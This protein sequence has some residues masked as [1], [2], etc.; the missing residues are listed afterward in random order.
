MRPII[1]SF[2]IFLTTSIAAQ[3]TQSDKKAIGVFEKLLAKL[4]SYETMS[5]NYY[6]NLNYFSENYHR[7]TDGNIFLDFR[8]KDTALGFKYQAENKSLKSV[9]NGSETFYL[10]KDDTTIKVSF[11]AQI[12]H[13]ET[14]PVFT[15]SIITLKNALPKIINDGEVRKELADT[16]INGKSYH[17]ASFVLQN[18]TLNNLG[19]YA[20]ITL[21]RNFFYKI[22][23]DKTTF[24]PLHI[25]QTNSAE[26]KDYILTSFSNLQPNISQVPENSW[27]YSTY[28][29]DFK[30]PSDKAVALIKKNAIA[31][32]WE[33]TYF[34]SNEAISLS[35]LKG[36]VVLLEFWI[37]NCGYCVAAVP[38]LNYLIKKY[39]NRNLAV[40]GINRHDKQDD[41]DFFYGKHQP[42]FN[43][44]YDSNGNI[45]TAYGV[46]GFPT[47]VLIDKEGN[48][49]YAGSLD[50]ELLDGLLKTALE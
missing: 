20:P 2:F 26:P 40:I 21:K 46:D 31:P 38:E 49:I 1:I 16:T 45:A 6:R 30:P 47:I 27:F 15:N 4:S 34:K 22:I 19:G 17:L 5:Y 18:K 28:M 25:I 50:K 43:T 35:K 13:F 12:G 39:N 11:K 36:K 44:V 48:V 32:D 33:A 14:L 8:S 37:K 24:L 3:P 9:Y 29:K 41:V 10:N 42:N 23:V 7:E